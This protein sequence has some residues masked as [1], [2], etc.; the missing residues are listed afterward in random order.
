MGRSVIGQEPG[1]I[2]SIQ[3][4]LTGTSASSGN[5]TVNFTINSV[6]TSTTEVYATGWSEV[7]VARELTGSTTLQVGFRHGNTNHYWR[8]GFTITEFYE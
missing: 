1:S 5:T 7:D 2:K 6:N 4:L 3:H 8:K